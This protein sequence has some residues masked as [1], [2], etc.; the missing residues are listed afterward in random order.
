MIRYEPFDW[1]DEPLYY[2]IIFDVDT[3]REAEFL[4]GVM[5]RYGTGGRRVLEPACGSGRLVGAMAARGYHVTGFDLNAAALRFARRRLRDAGLRARFGKASMAGFDFG[6]RFDA[7]HC[8]VST[9]KYLLDAKSARRNLE[10]VAAAL[11]P[12][13]AYVLGLHLSEYGTTVRARERWIAA[14]DGVTVT[15][16]LQVWPPDRH[17]RTERVRCRLI[18]EGDGPT[19][20]LETN[21]QFRTYDL[22]QVRSL[23]KSVRDL[24]HVAT[25][26]FD[27]DLDR[28][29]P[30]DGEW[31]DNVLVL[32]KK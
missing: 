12:G 7:A 14:R 18:V 32:R 21:W 13:G 16:N 28:P 24:E 29:T 5:E 1:Y 10:C 26:H 17:R 23:L 22:R 2:D 9:F 19:R 4:E 25:F 27:C 20:H 31:L 3:A 6:C 8:L 15:C 30:F 11:K